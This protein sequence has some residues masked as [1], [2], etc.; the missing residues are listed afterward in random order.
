MSR[1]TL[2]LLGSAEIRDAASKAVATPLHQPKRLGLLSYLAAARPRGFHRRDK[3]VALFWPEASQAQARH[4]LSQVLHVLRSELG[5]GAIRTRG[6]S[7]VALDDALISC[8]VVAFERA[9]DDGAHEQALE[10][11]RGNLLDALFVRDAPEFERWLDDERTWL[12]EKAAGAAWALAHEHIRAGRLVDAER[13]A[14]RAL[15]L[16]A[17]DGS[18]VRRFIQ[19][20]ADA[21]DRAAALRFYEKFAQRLRSE[22]ALE[23]DPATVAVSQTLSGAPAD[24]EHAAGPP[25][26]VDR[27][28]PPGRV[29]PGS[30]MPPPR[31]T[32]GR[33]A[34]RAGKFRI[35]LAVAALVI[36]VTSLVLLQGRA[37]DTLDRNRVLVV[38]L[39]D[40]SGRDEVEALGSWA[41][42]HI[43]QVLTES[44][45]AEVVDPVTT[46][47]VSEDAPVPGMAG[48]PEDI[49]ALARDAQA[50]TV[51]SG[52][53][54]AERD[55]VHVQVRITDANDG[56][57]I[58]T[59]GPVI[60]PIAT[61]RDLVAT[62]GHEVTLALAPV[63][64]RELGAFEPAVKPGSYEAYLAYREGLR[65]W[66]LGEDWL[67][68]ARHFERAV[69]ADSTF[70][71]GR[72]WAAKIH[73]IVGGH[74]NGWTGVAKAE[75]LLAPLVASPE[76][77]SRYER[78][79]L[80]FVQAL[81]P[82]RHIPSMYDATRCMVEVA[83]GSDNAK[84]ELQLNALRVNRPREALALWRDIHPVKKRPGYWTIPM[85]AYHMLGD[86]ERELD[87]TRQGLERFP[88]HPLL[89]LGEVSA[90][91][92]LDRKDAA[93]AGVESIR[94]LP[95]RERPLWVLGWA[96]DELRVHGHR[97]AAQEA[98][99]ESIAW[100]SSQPHDTE[101]SR[102]ELAGLLY[103]AERWDEARSLYEELAE[104][105]PENTWYLADIGRLAART[106]DRDEALRIS[107]DLRSPSHNLM[108]G[109]RTQA[110][111]RIAAVLGDRQQAM[112]L[113]RE[114]FD[115]GAQ[116]N[117]W[118]PLHS[119]MDFESLH[120]YP[121]F[122][123]FLRPKG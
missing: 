22:Y 17:T 1:F 110:R 4:S 7:D 33:A 114:A 85:T 121:P 112:T 8:D 38:A 51:V 54:Y 116:W 84:G 11:Y 58:G 99:S 81:R 40:N 66:A 97:E 79:Q 43:I 19:A 61:P 119:D 49:I 86:Y 71:R 27:T 18:Q 57:V 39:T 45:F 105:Y 123:E 111:A 29:T 30:R 102:V 9:V 106:G 10:L 91:A 87:I 65:A 113:L 35:G 3:L 16:V 62:I 36:A 14:Q 32:L 107:E 44:G 78:C 96:I 55:S 64:D 89:M 56:S 117:R 48:A 13:T 47:E 109:Y 37:G 72:L 93:R 31:P 52:S 23:P 115:W 69:E 90:L 70:A 6:D 95:A 100:L 108:E 2:R 46:L 53:Y 92:A 82:P 88:Q 21:G 15:L 94:S 83:P 120:D 80:Q 118:P 25:G 98:L 101:Q 12:R 26:E 20:L 77:L 73:T 24:S 76:R 59:A 104:K 5:D 67:V 74:N 75:S 63:L 60:G 41:Q 103:R 122:Q 50:G 28:E 34:A 68:A 42:D